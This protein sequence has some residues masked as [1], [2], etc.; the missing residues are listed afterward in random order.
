LISAQGIFIEGG[1]QGDYIETWNGTLVQDAIHAVFENGGAIGGTSAGLA[2]LGEVVYNATGG[3]LYPDKAAYNP[4][5][6]DITLTDDFLDIL[7]NVF[8]DS[9]FFPR[10]RI[11]RLVP[12][13][14]R[15]I[16]DYNQTDLMGVGVCDNTALCIDKDGNG[17]A[18]GD[19]T[20]TILYKSEKSVIECK[21]GQAVTFTHIV[22]HNLTRGAVFNFK[23]RK[24]IDPGPFLIPVSDYQTNQPFQQLRLS[25]IEDS[26]ATK[27]S[28]RI[29]GLTSDKS[30]AWTGQLTQ[31]VG[32]NLL[33][34]SVILTKL[35]WENARNETYYYENR[36][37]GGIW[38]IA[39]NPGYKAIYLN[40]DAD[41]STFNGLIDVSN[42][43]V[44]TVEQGI[45]YILDTFGITHKC[46]NYTRT[47]NRATNYRGMVNARLFFLKENDQYDLSNQPTK[48]E[49]NKGSHPDHSCELFQ[50]YPNPFNPSTAIRCILSDDMFVEISV[51]NLSGQKVAEIFNG[52]LDEGLHIFQFNASTLGTGM[53]ICS[54]KTQD[55]VDMKKMIL[56]R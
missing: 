5:H 52:N 28:V 13:L 44:L 29:N 2:V 10:G 41:N 40:G 11:A 14:A 3:Y 35:L 18:W 26:S 19:A 49:Q 31:S 53:Y 50:N 55:Y 12:M 16:V 22:F 27:G 48:V 51:F 1:D 6:P 46:E 21:P 25:G 43:G 37:I 15:R 45:V 33:P 9:H 4:Y 24:L 7:P 36:W 8:T 23:S 47:G 42:T 39:D 32:E 20:V 56:V 54:M 30:A 38:G 34:N 17:K